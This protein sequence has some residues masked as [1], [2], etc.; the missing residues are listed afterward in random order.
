MITIHVFGKEGCAKCA[1]LKSRLNGILQQEPY[2]GKF[3]MEYTDVLKEDDLV[4]FCRAQCVNP[5]K[6]PAM[7]LADE[8]GFMDGG[9]RTDAP[10]TYQYLGVQTD[11]SEKGKGIL[12]PDLI[13]SVLDEA[14]SKKGL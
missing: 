9:C 8:N 4:R 3:V 2:K 6:I 13:K 10:R 12:P 5:S 7:L 1:L 14:L 11:Y